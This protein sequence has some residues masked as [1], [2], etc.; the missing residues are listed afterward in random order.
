MAKKSEEPVPNYNA[1]KRSWR[2]RE[3]QE[4]EQIKDGKMKI[5]GAGNVGAFGGLDMEAKG[6]IQKKMRLFYLL[7]EPQHVAHHLS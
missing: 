1:K 7:V 3:Q 4:Q 2:I 6:Q 5:T